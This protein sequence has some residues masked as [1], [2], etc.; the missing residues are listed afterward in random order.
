MPLENLIMNL[1]LNY[2]NLIENNFFM[3]FHG[4]SLS[5]FLLPKAKVGR[6]R[7]DNRLII[8]GILYVLIQDVNGEICL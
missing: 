8:N 7:T 6:P 2:L 1:S 5:L 4:L 3:E